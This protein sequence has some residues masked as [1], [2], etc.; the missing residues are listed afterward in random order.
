MPNG[1]INMKLPPSRIL[2]QNT[3]MDATPTSLKF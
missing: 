1:L 3:P 2:E